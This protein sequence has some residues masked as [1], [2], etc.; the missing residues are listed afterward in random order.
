VT[1][2]TAVPYAD[3]HLGPAD[4]HVRIPPL[5]EIGQSNLATGRI[6]DRQPVGGKIPTSRE[7]PDRSES[8]SAV[9]RKIPAS[10]HQ[11]CPVL[12]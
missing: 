3:L 11:K 9:C 1:V 10:S 5:N 8:W 6:A 4:N 7:N 2:A 12:A